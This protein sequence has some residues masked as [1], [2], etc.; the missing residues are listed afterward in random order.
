MD[1][2]LHKLYK[3]LYNHQKL[4]PQINTCTGETVCYKSFALVYFLKHKSKHYSKTHIVWLILEENYQF[5]Q[6]PKW[7]EQEWQYYPNDP[8]SHCSDCVFVHL[9]WRHGQI[10]PIIFILLTVLSMGCGRDRT[11]EI[12]KDETKRWEES[13]P[14]PLLLCHLQKWVTKRKTNTLQSHEEC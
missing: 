5:L 6:G 4:L 11:L 7:S 1:S 10:F 8:L 13:Y 9:S 3:S 14:R 12:R 2:S